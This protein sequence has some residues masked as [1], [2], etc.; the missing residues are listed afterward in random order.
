[1]QS[2][3]PFEPTP[4]EVERAREA[5]ATRIVGP[6]ALHVRLDASTL[7]ASVIDDLKHLLANF[8]G[9]WEVVLEVKMS[10]GDPRTLRLGPSFKVAPTPTLRA[11]LEHVLGPAALIAG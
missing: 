4:E 2:A 6:L 3:E 9:E 7:P 5:A 1:V 8:P 10:A 11:E